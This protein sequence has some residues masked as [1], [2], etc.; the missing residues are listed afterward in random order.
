MKGSVYINIYTKTNSQQ[1]LSVGAEFKLIVS[2]RIKIELM[3]WNDRKKMY[4]D[5]Q[6]ELSWLECVHKPSYALGGETPS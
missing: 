6:C 3:Y 1:Y 5:F 4:Y 2:D